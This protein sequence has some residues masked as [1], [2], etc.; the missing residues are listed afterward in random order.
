VYPLNS[1][2]QVLVL[3]HGKPWKSYSSRC[4]SHEHL[5][6][7][8][9]L[10]KTVEM[11]QRQLEQQQ[12]NAQLRRNHS[13]ARGEMDDQNHFGID[14]DSSDDDLNNRRQRRQPMRREG[15]MKVEVLEFDGKMQS[16]VFLDWLSTVERIFEF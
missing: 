5:V 9:E 3:H 15:D 12:N 13:E 6:E 10:R 2:I 16:G 4:S 11:L 7:L 14:D 8:A 1:A